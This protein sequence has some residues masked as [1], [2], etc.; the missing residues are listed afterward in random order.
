MDVG[1]PAFA[2]QALPCEPTALAPDGSQVRVL[3]GLAGGGMAHFSLAPG[4]VSKAVA[5]RSVEEIWYVVGGRGAMWRRHGAYEQVITLEPGVCLTIPLGTQ[6]QFR[7]DT[8]AEPLAAIGI[9]MPPWPGADEA[10]AVDGPWAAT[11]G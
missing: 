11:A 7:A 9:T 8:G 2:T 4:Q 1:S 10:V 3:L 6:F 5:H